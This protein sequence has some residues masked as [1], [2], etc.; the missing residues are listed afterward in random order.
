VPAAN[1][2]ANRIDLPAI[3]ATADRH[4]SKGLTAQRFKELLTA[5]LESEYGETIDSR[6]QVLARRWGMSKRKVYQLYAEALR[7]R[8]GRIDISWFDPANIEHEIARDCG[9]FWRFCQ[10]L[11]NILSVEEFMK[12]CACDQSSTTYVFGLAA[13]HIRGDLSERKAARDGL[14]ERLSRVQEPL[15]TDRVFSNS[16][17]KFSDALF[18]ALQRNYVRARFEL[19][20][21][22]I[23]NKR[24]ECWFETMLT[25]SEVAVGVERELKAIVKTAG[26]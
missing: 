21:W 9:L 22:E 1:T 19:R 8:V 24:I 2:P 11:Q 13:R 14:I 26:S 20:L 15:A 23:E 4:R 12:A 16:R 5:R 25:A 18:L 7:A 6:F 3:E 10:E 17:L